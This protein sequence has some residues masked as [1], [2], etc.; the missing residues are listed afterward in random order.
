MFE[1]RLPVAVAT[2]EG[3]ELFEGEAFLEEGHH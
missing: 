3:C 2:W 1:H